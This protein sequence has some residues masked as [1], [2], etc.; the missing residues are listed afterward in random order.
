MNN[1][2]IENKKQKGYFEEE[3]GP[4]GGGGVSEGKEGK[5]V[6]NTMICICVDAIM[7]PVILYTN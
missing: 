1:N 2:P 5:H 6:Q 7:K 4:S 3:K